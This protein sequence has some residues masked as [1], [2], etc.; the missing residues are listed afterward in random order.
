MRTLLYEIIIKFAS[1]RDKNLFFLEWDNNSSDVNSWQKY[2][3]FYHRL[4]YSIGII[5]IRVIL[6]VHKQCHQR[7]PYCVNII[8]S[9]FF[10][11]W[12]KLLFLHF[13]F[14]IRIFDAIIN[15][16]PDVMLAISPRNQYVFL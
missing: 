14:R 6:F 3:F 2:D 8:R 1:D 7:N 16:D 10:S 4:I 9:Q 11:I 12:T 13:F 5:I 15:T